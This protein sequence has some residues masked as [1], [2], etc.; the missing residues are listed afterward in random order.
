MLVTV[1]SLVDSSGAT[2]AAI[3]TD[4]YLTMVTVNLR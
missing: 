2:A 4:G 3:D 1:E